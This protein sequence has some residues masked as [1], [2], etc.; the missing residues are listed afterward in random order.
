MSNNGQDDGKLLNVEFQVRRFIE[1]VVER[2]D[3]RGLSIDPLG[4]FGLGLSG[5][6]IFYVELQSC[7]QQI[8]LF[9]YAP[10][11]IPI[12]ENELFILN[13][14][15][16]AEMF[17]FIVRVVVMPNEGLV[18]FAIIESVEIDSEMLE[19]SLEL[20]RL[21]YRKLQEFFN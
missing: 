11:E 2:N 12:T 4:G 6:D 21:R 17:D 10:W 5:G 15:P 8:V 13:D 14:F 16:D 18:C 1:G 3:I 19:A 7:G 20:L 9:F